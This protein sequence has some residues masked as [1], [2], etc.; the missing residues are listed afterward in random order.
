MGTSGRRVGE[1]FASKGRRVTALGEE[2]ACGAAAPRVASLAHLERDGGS[3]R[4]HG[5][6]RGARAARRGEEGGDRVGG[7]RAHHARARQPP[8]RRRVRADARDGRTGCDDPRQRVDRERRGRWPEVGEEGVEPVG[9]AERAVRDVEAE[10]ERVVP[11]RRQRLL[12]LE[13]RRRDKVGLVAKSAGG[14]Q[15]GLDLPRGELGEA[16]GGRGGDVTGRCVARD[17][18]QRARAAGR[19]VHGEVVAARRPEHRAR[20]RA[21]L[22][23]PLDDEARCARARDGDV[24][25]AGAKLGREGVQE[26]LE[27]AQPLV[28]ARVGREIDASREERARRGG[29]ARRDGP[30]RRFD[31]RDTD[32]GGAKVKP[33]SE[34]RRAWQDGRHPARRAGEEHVHKS[35]SIVALKQ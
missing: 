4:A 33:G 14:R 19:A 22:R 30:A 34:A 9:V 7:A 15:R 17:G 26:C 3:E 21:G 27:R 20:V 35:S 12:G 25:Q 23:M 13:Q 6:A 24:G 31:E 32:A 5:C 1:A 2:E 10:L 28:R 18:R 11:V 8:A 29:R 16:R